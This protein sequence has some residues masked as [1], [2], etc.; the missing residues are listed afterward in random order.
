[1]HRIS[2]AYVALSL[3][4][5]APAAFCG[6]GAEPTPAPFTAPNYSLADTPLLA[7]TRWGSSP[8]LLPLETSFGL[9]P[10]HEI[11]V[12]TLSTYDSTRATYRYTLMEQPHWA[13][14]VG[15]TSTMRDT[16]DLLRSSWSS[17][18]NGTL[19][20]VHIGGEARFTPR[21]LL[22]VDADGLATHSGR[23]FDIGLRVN[24]SLSPSFSLYGGLRVSD[25]ATETD[26]LRNSA[27]TN[28][29]NAANV[30]LRF[31]F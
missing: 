24:Y 1:M 28:T 18:R 12:S 25:G 22:A 17:A 10:R 3:V 2:T 7:A 14:K 6:T 11:R 15:L 20:S 19:P 9:A 26:E 27:A 16:S 13:W 8:R 4:L 31:N 21:W 5:W 30:G 23:L 29:S